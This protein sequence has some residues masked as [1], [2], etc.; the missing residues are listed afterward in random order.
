MAYGVKW[1]K[2]V[3]CIFFWFGEATKGGD[4]ESKKNHVAKLHPTGRWPTDNTGNPQG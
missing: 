2:Y 3:A 4:L 1:C